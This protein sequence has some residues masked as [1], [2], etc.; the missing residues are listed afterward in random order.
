MAGT[1]HFSLPQE[2]LHP[3]FNTLAQ[4][5]DSRGAGTGG[6]DEQSF[7]LNIA[8]ALWSQEDYRF[9]SEFLDLL[10]ANYG[11]EMRR[12]DFREEEARPAVNHW[13]SQ[14][15]EGRI[16]ELIPPGALDAST[17]LLL[18]NAVYFK[19]AWASPFESHRT[20]WGVFHLLD[21][22]VVTT[23]MMNQGAAFAYTEG[24]DYQAVQL[25]YEGDEM[26]MVILLPAQG[27]FEAFERSL[28]AERLEAILARLAERQ[29]VLTMPRF[30]F[31]SGFDLEAVLAAMGMPLAFTH[32]ADFSGMNPEGEL[33]IG[34][35]IHGATISVDEAGT[36]ATAATA[37]EVA[38]TGEA[39]DATTVT[40]DRPF[41]FLIRDLQ[42]GTTLFLGR[43]V[44]PRGSMES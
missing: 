20:Q 19:A 39:L 38:V 27:Q 33:F 6:T 23:P 9:R 16:E 21:G 36:E 1:L 15:T 29:V 5:L 2:Q 12:V 43:V 28:D 35:V 8:N 31:E 25:P 17:R 18:T 13:I 10:A 44:D 14:Q 30:E 4:E 22:S 24:P 7:R 40:V 11:A 32:Q 34:D 42:T 37:V 3:A 26:A 41:L